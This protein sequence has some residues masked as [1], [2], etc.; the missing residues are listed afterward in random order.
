MKNSDKEMQMRK[1]IYYQNQNIQFLEKQLWQTKQELAYK[2]AQL[3]S[4]TWQIMNKLRNEIY[5]IRHLSRKKIVASNENK[6]SSYDAFLSFDST[7]HK[8]ENEKIPKISTEIKAIAYYK[9]DWVTHESFWKEIEFVTPRNQAHNQPRKPLED[10]QKAPFSLD[11]YQKQVSLAKTHGIF[12][13]C[14]LWDF[15]N[16]KETL[17]LEKV[18][19]SSIDMPFV[20]CISVPEKG[21][22]KKDFYQEFTKE[23][24]KFIK[25][26]RYLKVH[27][28]PVLM[29]ANK[30]EI[31]DLPTFVQNIRSSFE[32][33]IEL[34]QNKKIEDQD[35]T[36]I[37][38]F[39]GEFQLEMKG[40]DLLP[41]DSLNLYDYEFLSRTVKTVYRAHCS[42]LPYYYCAFLPVDESP[43]EISK[44]RIDYHYTEKEFYFFTNEVIR[45][46]RDMHDEEERIFFIDS[47]NDWYR[48]TYLEPDQG[49]GYTYLNTFTK[50]LFGVPLTTPY[51]IL[52]E[53]DQKLEKLNKKIAIQVHLFYTDLTPEVIQCLKKIPYT[54][55]CYIST[56]SVEKKKRIETYFSKEKNLPK[57]I[58][59]VFENRGRD[60]FPFLQQMN[61]R[62]Q[63]YAYIAHIHTKKTLTNNHGER[64]RKYLYK[65]LFGSEDYLKRLFYLMEKN[66]NL[67]IVF[68]CIYNDVINDCTLVGNEKYL[69]DL[70]QRLQIPQEFV[71]EGMLFPAG[72]MFWAKTDALKNLIQTEFQ[73]E[74]FPEENR[75]DDATLAHGIERMFCAI[76]KANGY[77]SLQ[78]L[79]KD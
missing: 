51:K 70:K 75:Q 69:E 45:K 33:E 56:D 19:E 65:N 54:F 9:L 29:I 3:N 24:Q 21:S 23:V 66:E 64:W 22:Q 18:I 6:G 39:D 17:Y 40:N 78:I 47:W 62:I 14:F 8:E 36:N 76:A 59:E 2:N 30:D 74:D 67:G 31:R 46:T 28:K 57:P 10:W 4:K 37:E 79:K 11:V 60:I 49:R 53:S 16:R 52:G 1:Q 20:L 43:M 32:E 26:P 72:S 77:D 48:G 58:I 55:D 41:E 73:K 61:K 27:G 15:S 42:I 13:F 25:D 35:Q 44:P 38:I 34:W 12:G 68:P 5:K 7:L 71:Y 50:S 63:Q